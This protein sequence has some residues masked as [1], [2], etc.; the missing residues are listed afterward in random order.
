[1]SSE[2]KENVGKRKASSLKEKDAEE[3]KRITQLRK[4]T[5]YKHLTETIEKMEKR[6]Q[7][8]K[9]YKMRDVPVPPVYK[10]DIMEEVYAGEKE[11]HEDWDKKAREDGSQNN[12]AIDYL[13]GTTSR[14][15]GEGGL[16]EKVLIKY[17]EY[18]VPSWGDL[19][20]IE[21][22][23]A[24]DDLALRVALLDFVE[25]FLIE[26]LGVKKFKKK[27]GSR[28]LQHEEG[29]GEGCYVSDEW[30]LYTNRLRAIEYSWNTINTSWSVPHIYIEDWTGKECDDEALRQLEYIQKSM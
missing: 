12:C 18:P 19:E 23:S 14:E 3:T 8:E 30:S 20:R 26:K 16:T 15:R 4:D 7:V 9:V 5:E 28:Y 2:D 21:Q 25:L 1:R 17:H 24:Q 6:M 22:G 10:Y 27:Y 11:T 13:V 29:Q